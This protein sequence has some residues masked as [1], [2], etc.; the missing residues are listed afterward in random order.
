MI[1]RNFK[2]KINEKQTPSSGVNGNDG[3]DISTD[4]ITSTS[5]SSSDGNIIKNASAE[6]KISN[7]KLNEEKRTNSNNKIEKI[8]SASVNNNNA[9]SSKFSIDNGSVANKSLKIDDSK[10]SFIDNVN[11][12]EEDESDKDSE[13]ESES[14]S[15]LDDASMHFLKY[16]SY[17]H[18][19]GKQLPTTNSYQTTLSNAFLK[20]PTIETDVNI[21][22]PP[23]P[24]PTQG[25]FKQANKKLFDTTSN[26]SSAKN[27]LSDMKR[28]PSVLIIFVILM[29]I[30]R[31]SLKTIS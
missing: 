17:H 3:D 22:P 31:L 14:E 1:K 6:K 16:K 30:Q 2:G 18:A 25:W 13:T 26:S 23:T 21:K 10:F 24:T 5:S 28:R 4:S 15:D 19:I 7:N 12:N 8:E 9:S 11:E 27:V 29:F 20:T